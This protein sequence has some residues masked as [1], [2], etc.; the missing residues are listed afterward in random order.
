[1][2]DNFKNCDFYVS[3]NW[4]HDDF[5]LNDLLVLQTEK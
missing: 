5:N 2:D 1:M 3:C 4:N